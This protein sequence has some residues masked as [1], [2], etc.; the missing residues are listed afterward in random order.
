MSGLIALAYSLCGVEFV[1]LRVLYPGMWRNARGFTNM[2]ERELAPVTNQLSRV[3]W[4][5]G[6]IPLLA[7]VVMLFLGDT[8]NFRMLVTGLILLGMAGFHVASAVTR[9]LTQVV[10]ILTGAKS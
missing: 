2:A 8:A 6:S 7:A 5:A 1:I 10:V 3:Q 9:E 4:L